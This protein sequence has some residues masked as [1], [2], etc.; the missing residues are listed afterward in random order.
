MTQHNKQTL[1]RGVLVREIGRWIRDSNMDSLKDYIE[2]END[3]EA[4]EADAAIYGVSDETVRA[5]LS[6]LTE[7][8]VEWLKQYQGSTMPRRLFD[9]MFKAQAALGKCD[10]IG[11]MEYRRKLSEWEQQIAVTRNG[12]DKELMLRIITA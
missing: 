1:T 9:E 8:I 2:D 3:W 4:F 6:D 7:E 12:E 11:G 5:H 10:S